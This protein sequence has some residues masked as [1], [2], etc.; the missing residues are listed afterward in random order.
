M[1]RVQDMDKLL[2]KLDFSAPNVT[3]KLTELGSNV[4]LLREKEE[5]YNTLKD[6]LEI[7]QRGMA[8]NDSVS[9]R[10]QIQK[11]LRTMVDSER[12]EPHILSN[13]NLNVYT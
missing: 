1:V 8:Q 7:A 10:T 12:F 6:K 4:G 9:A 2:R 13:G 3:G 5:C 11:L